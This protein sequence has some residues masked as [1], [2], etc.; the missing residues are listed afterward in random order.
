M[1]ILV[2]SPHP[3]ALLGAL[4]GTGDEIWTTSERLIEEPNVDFVVSYGYRH[5]L[6]E[7]L[8]S[9]FNRRIINIHISMLPWNRGADP[10]FWSWFDGTP[11]G[12]SIHYIDA[13]IDTGDLLAQ[14]GLVFSEYETLASS[15][16]KLHEK[17]INLFSETWP[18]IRADK[19]SAVRQEGLGSYHR[20]RDKEAWWQRLPLGYDTPV[21]DVEEMGLRRNCLNRQC[22]PR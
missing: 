9:R 7:P 16:V 11:K 10:N 3:V 14:A 19:I 15:Y 5:I 6:R 21:A 17:A 8:L 2:L 13:G 12:T 22:M 1:K 18:L 4:K 20:S